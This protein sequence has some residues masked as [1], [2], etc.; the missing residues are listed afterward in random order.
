MRTDLKAA[1]QECWESSLRER[2]RLNP[3]ST[4]PVL[5]ALLACH[6]VRFADG[7]Y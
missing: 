3:R 7:I 4:V 1:L 2:T 5:D 6:V